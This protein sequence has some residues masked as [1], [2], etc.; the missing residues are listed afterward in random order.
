MTRSV[1]SYNSGQLYCHLN[2]LK[3]G[4]QFHACMYTAMRADREMKRVLMQNQMLLDIEQRCFKD[5]HGLNESF[6]T[7]KKYYKLRAFC[8]GKVNLWYFNHGDSMLDLE[9]SRMIEFHKAVLSELTDEHL[10]VDPLRSFYLRG[11]LDNPTYESD[12]QAKNSRKSTVG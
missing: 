2:D 6:S 1:R 12:Y 4:Q 7:V 10:Y 3:K 11:D 9:I 5:F 8:H